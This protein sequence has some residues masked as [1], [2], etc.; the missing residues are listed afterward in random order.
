[1]ADFD[2]NTVKQIQE[3]MQASSA[4]KQKGLASEVTL[5]TVSKNIA[6][7]AKEMGVQ[8][9]SPEKRKQTQ[10]LKDSNEAL[11]SHTEA[12][13]RNTSK[14]QILTRAFDELRFS[15]IGATQSVGDFAGVLNYV[16]DRMGGTFELVF[17]GLSTFTQML[18]DQIQTFRNI[19]QVGVSFGESI[20]DSRRIAGELGVSLDVLQNAVIQGSRAFALL[21]GSADQ[22]AQIFKDAFNKTAFQDTILSLTAV[23]FT[24]D[25]IAGGMSD[26]LE[27]QTEIGRGQRMTA[28]QLAQESGVFLMN[29]D[30]LSKAT[31]RQRKEILDQMQRD[32]RDDR[33][34]SILGGMADGGQEVLKMLSVLETSSPEMANNV[35]DLI[36]NMGIPQ[37]AAQ[38]G[39][40]ANS[41]IQSLLRDMISGEGS[42]TDVMAEFARLGKGSADLT[43]E[44]RRLFTFLNAQGNG[45][46]NYNIQL[47]NA[48]KLF[49]QYQAAQKLQDAQVRKNTD[50]ALQFDRAVMKLRARFAALT[51][52]ILDFLDPMFGVFA[53]AIEG[54]ANMLEGDFSKALEG[55]AGLILGLGVAV[56]GVIAAMKALKAIMSFLPGIGSIGMKGGGA[57]LGGMKAIGAGGAAFGK[58]AA[59]A[60]LGAGVGVGGFAALA[61]GGIA[62]GLFLVGKSLNVLAEGLERVQAIDGSALKDTAD[63]TKMLASA[64]IDLGGAQLEGGVSGFFGKLFGGGTENFAKSINKTLDQLDKDKIDVYATSINNLGESMQSLSTGMQSVTTGASKSTG[65]KLDQLNTTMQ[66][67]LYVL[68]S[69]NRYMKV[70]A[71]SST[72]VAENI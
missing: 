58:G 54:I 67:I 46:Y 69:S 51:T 41:N 63:G 2:E 62:A 17:R 49:E 43:M 60:G 68:G 40:V 59:L 70:T 11:E 20:N 1:M 16:G 6:A 42:V 38:A 35:K 66:E 22:G 33:L 44:Q 34:R 19:N 13:E 71:R 29:L 61:G 4:A 39:L 48:G 8:T 26:F 28:M 47:A 65:D 25:E 14:S 30:L 15:G 10:N 31:G 7:M 55:T 37:N 64:I 56:V 21:G 23:G 32:T 3:L 57:M 18:E 9:A 50:G 72:E 5:E 27:L 45:F 24:M 53:T 12:A 36:A 52:F